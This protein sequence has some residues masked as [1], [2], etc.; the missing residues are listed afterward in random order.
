[1]PERADCVSGSANCQGAERI[2][3]MGLKSRGLAVLATH[4]ASHFWGVL[5]L[6]SSGWVFFFRNDIKQR[7]DFVAI[8]A[9]TRWQWH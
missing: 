8:A 6:P 3:A 4:G 1:M 7:N 2:R 9:T 5:A